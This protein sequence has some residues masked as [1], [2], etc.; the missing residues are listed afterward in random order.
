MS[1]FDTLPHHGIQSLNPYVPGKSIEAVAKEY[2]LTNIIKLASNENPLGCSPLVL[3]AL[4]QLNGHQMATYPA[5]IQ[6]PIYSKLAQSLHVTQEQLIICNGTDPFFSLLMVCFCLHNGRTVLT[7]D[8]AF[9]TYEIQAQTLGIAV[10]KTPVNE[11]WQPDVEALIQACDTNTGIIFLANPN[12]PTGSY[13]PLSDIQRILERIPRTTLL[14]LDEA[15]FEYAYDENDTGA[16]GLLDQ[17]ENLIVTRTFSKIYGLAGLRIGFA[18]AHPD[19]IRWLHRVQLPFSVNYAAMTAAVAALDDQSFIQDSRRL[20]AEGLQQLS[21]G[22][23]A[24][25][26]TC[27]PTKA[28]FITFDCGR[29]AQPIDQFL[30]KAGVIV[31]PLRP[32]QLPQHLRVTAG[33]FVQNER[34]LTGLRD[35]LAH[36]PI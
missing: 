7:H 29:N 20:N 23:A 13:L 30:Q 21:E 24:L 5:P 8:Y 25:K 10:K 11:N 18:L 9:S 1:H 27:L 15:Y 3:E 26:L 32:Y 2:G 19:V 22:L 4:Q 34:F 12:N 16:Q 28:N 33:D 31:R 14:V 17:F 35:A 36:A 6:H